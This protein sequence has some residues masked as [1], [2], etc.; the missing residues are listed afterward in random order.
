MR[1]KAVETL[2][3]QKGLGLDNAIAAS[4]CVLIGVALLE[5]S[6]VVECCMVR[7][8]CAR[9]AWS[10]RVRCGRSIVVVWSGAIVPFAVGIPM[11]MVS[12]ALEFRARTSCLVGDCT[13]GDVT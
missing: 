13:P 5:F 3:C 11:L 10:P 1:L 6:N 9:D 12:V 8:H 2:V 7:P 4:L